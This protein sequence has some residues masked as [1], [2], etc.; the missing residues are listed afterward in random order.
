MPFLYKRAKNEH[1]IIIYFYSYSNL[2]LSKPML[3]RCRMLGFRAADKFKPT[4]VR[5]RKSQWN[6]HFLRGESSQIGK[7]DCK[8]APKKQRIK[9]VQIIC[10]KP[11]QIGAKLILRRC[12]N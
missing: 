7:T 3:S 12:K 5:Y 8:N 2:N 1:Y 6:S 4:F 10:F 9:L 11:V